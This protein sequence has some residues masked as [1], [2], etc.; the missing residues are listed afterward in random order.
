MNSSR[1]YLIR[2]LYEWIVDDDCTPHFLVDVEYPQVLVPGAHATDGQIV[3]EASATALPHLHM[4]NQAV[5]FES[6]FGAVPHSLHS[7]IGSLTAISARENGQGMACEP[8]PP[9]D[10][11]D[12]TDDI[13]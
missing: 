10:D 7:P 2:A 4:H 5:R 8:E 3:R 6:R 12:S 13:G 9:Q 11:S 1:P